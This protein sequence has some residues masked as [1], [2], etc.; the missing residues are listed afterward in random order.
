[1]SNKPKKGKGLHMLD[2]RA[3]GLDKP[4]VSTAN[5]SNGKTN[6]GTIGHVDQEVSRTDRVLYYT[7]KT[8]YADRKAAM[9]EQRQ[10]NP[11]LQQNGLFL[12]DERRVGDVRWAYTQARHV[13][14][15]IVRSYDEAVMVVDGWIKDGTSIDRMS[16]DYCLSEYG[17]SN[18][19]TGKD[20][21]LW[22]IERVKAEK[23]NPNSTMNLGP[24]F[25]DINV[26]SQHYTGADEIRK[27]IP[28]LIDIIEDYD[29][30]DIADTKGEHHDV[31]I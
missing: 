11:H 15:W 27:L 3:R 21:M 17:F 19:K 22:F 12:D 23:A 14:W 29:N 1:M 24:E 5:R 18:A 10:N 16:L 4:K 30:G 9:N 6:V 8:T 25:F 28:T 31:S 20:F 26:H 2:R 7:G 13:A